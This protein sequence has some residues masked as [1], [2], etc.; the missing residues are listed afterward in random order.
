MKTNRLL[1]LFVL[2]VAALTRTTPAQAVTHTT[3]Y[4]DGLTTGAWSPPNPNDATTTM[5]ATVMPMLCCTAVGGGECYKAV[6]DKPYTFSYADSI[7]LPEVG[8][9]FNGGFIDQTFHDSTLV[10]ENWHRDYIG[11]LLNST[12][13]RL[14]TWSATYES[15]KANSA[16]AALGLG[17]MDLAN[18]LAAARAAFVANRDADVTNAAFGHQ[19][20]VAV[21]QNI[22][23][24]NT[25][26]SQ[27]ANWGA[28][29]VAFANG[30][31][32][33]FAKLPGNCAC[34]PEPAT[35]ITLAIAVV[36]LA[37]ARSR[38]RRW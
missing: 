6:I 4:S 28:A 10:H 21:L 24:V 8:K 23:G 3:T 30:I 13:G 5:Q 32:V 38:R 19:N 36:G 1:L 25:W 12:Y 34:V 7:L 16:A 26:R 14:E 35:W 37:Q 11:A 18:A 27:N 31:N 22:D 33:N 29:A 9:T 17:N 2:L 20:A 15:N